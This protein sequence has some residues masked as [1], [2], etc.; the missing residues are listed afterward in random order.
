MVGLC[1]TAGM[2]AAM[3]PLEEVTLAWTHSIEKIRWEEDYR[4]THDRLILT[5]ARIKG[6]GAGMEPPEG[7]QLSNGVWHYRPALPPLERLRLTHSPY[8]K[9]YEICAAGRCRSLDE[10]LPGI[11][12]TVVVEVAPCNLD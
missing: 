6:S 5:E 7:A 10:I 8:A 4:V 11:A 3:L 1:L 9:T 12:N 2:I